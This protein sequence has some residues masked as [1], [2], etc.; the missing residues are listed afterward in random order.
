MYKYKHYTILYYSISN[1]CIYARQS[2]VAN[3]PKEF[4][5]LFFAEIKKENN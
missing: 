3:F 4:E 2:Y 5:N 1:F